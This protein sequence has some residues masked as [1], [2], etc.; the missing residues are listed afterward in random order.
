MQKRL[1]RAVAHPGGCVTLAY[2]HGTSTIRLIGQTIGQNLRDT[3]R[4]FPDH[5]ALIVPYQNVRLT[6]GEFDSKVDA[7]ARS[8]LAIGIDTGDRIGIWSPNNAEWVLI[9]YA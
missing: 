1:V 3:A 5:D 7:L 6:Y 2:S 9:Q 8:L 4:R